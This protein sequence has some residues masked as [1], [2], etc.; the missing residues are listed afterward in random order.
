M[1]KFYITT[2]IY[3]V[4]DK[5]HIGHAYST[6]IADVLARYHRAKGDE[7]AFSTGTDENSQKTID[8]AVKN[9]A[10]EKI[11]QYADQM[12][13]IWKH[14]WE[15]LDISY[16]RFIRTTEEDH[17]KV[18]YEIWKRVND[19]GDIYKGQ[20]E[21][22]YCVGH[23]AFMKESDLVDG[24]CPD[25]KKAP[26]R[27]KEENYFFKLSKYQKQLLAHY[28][29][30]PDFVM[31]HSRFHEVTSFV[32]SGLEDI[33]I[34]RPSKGWGIPVPG[35]ETQS[36]YVWFDAL[37]NYISAI[38]LSAWEDHPADLHAVG[39][40][41]TRFH[42]VIWPAMLF[43]AG[44]P[45]PAQ[46]GANGF[47]TID[48]VKISKSLGNAI[49]PLALAAKAGNDALRYFLLREIP[50]GEDGDFSFAKFDARYEGDLANG[51]GNFASRVTTLAEKYGPFEQGLLLDG[52][53]AEKIEAT[54][55]EVEAL[56][57][58]FKFHEV[59]QSVW[60]LIQVGDVMVNVTKPWETG[61]KNVLFTLVV[62]LDNIA[63]FLLPFMPVTSTAITAAIRHEGGAIVVK[64][65]AP[66]FPRIAGTSSS[67]S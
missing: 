13:E 33:S 29:S 67:P 56:I 2:P 52:A 26:E 19:A 57:N 11:M 66:L 58:Q 60:N 41:I 59:L 61:D 36:I 21:G 23:E 4:N 62:M 16:T 1:K 18:V 39:K 35:D 50:Y 25:H 14:T 8:A 20:Y 51:L 7:V 46:V 48:G 31:P 47:F 49:D 15:K 40:D 24:L 34:S 32:A 10:G 6:I 17:K 37:I 54:R 30:H 27:I 5:P 43:S 55:T 28:E 63:A 38:G 9:G 12:A 22:L 45:L 53:I 64:K 44:V 65:L 42:A 3:Y